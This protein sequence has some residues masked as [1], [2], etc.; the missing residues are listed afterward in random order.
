VPSK[1][2]RPAQKAKEEKKKKKQ[3]R[4]NMMILTTTTMELMETARQISPTM[5]SW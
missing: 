1:R 5:R 4:K 2:P 3:K